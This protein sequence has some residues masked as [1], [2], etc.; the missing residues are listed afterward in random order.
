MTGDRNEFARLRELFERAV[1]MPL[2]LRR[3]FVA[4]ECDANPGLRRQLEAMLDEDAAAG[5]L[6]DRDAAALTGR[7]LTSLETR[8]C[9]PYQL[10]ALLGEGGMG[11]VYRGRR[12]DLD[13]LAA[14][15]VLRDAWVSPARRERFE[16]EQRT[17]AR[18]H[19]TG[20]AAFLDAGVTAEGTPWIAMQ[21]VEGE[22]LLDYCRS[23]SLPVNARLGLFLQVCDAVQYAHER[24]I[25]HRDLKPSNILVDAAGAPKLLDFG[26]AKRI[27][28]TQPP[29]DAT[30]TELRLM[31]PKYAAPEQVR[32]EAAGVYTDVFALGVILGELIENAPGP[33]AWDELRVIAHK[34]AHNEVAARY[35]SADALAA[36]I[37]RYLAG[38]PLQ[39]RPDTALYRL[40]KLLVRHRAAVT[41]I[42]AA[43]LLAASL[44]A[45]FTWRLKQ[46]RDEAFAAANRAQRIQAFLLNLF[47]GGDK[48]AGPAHGLTV[49]TLIDRG[50]RE[51]PAL[52]REPAVQAEVYGT[53]GRMY[54][55]LGRYDAAERLLRSAIQRHPGGAREIESRIE[56]ALLR[57]EQ[58]RF[59]EAEALARRTI[60][61][62]PAD[63][64]AQEALGRILT[65]RGRYDDAVRILEPVLA[66]REQLPE[67]DKRATAASALASAHF[68]AGR[69]DESR[70]LNERA[71]GLR[72]QVH[73]ERHPYV[74]ADRTNLGAIDVDTG[75]YAQAEPQFRRALT[76][77]ETWYGPDHPETGSALTML[78]RCLVYQ[79]RNAEAQPL[80]RRALA[81]QE[82]VLGPAHARV[83]SVINDLGNIA[84]AAARYDE[85]ELYYRRMEDIYRQTRGDAHYLVAT[86]LSNR[87]NVYL[88]KGD[89]VRA[90]ALMHD[91][92]ARYTKALSASHT[93][94]AIARIRLGRTL[95]RQKRWR[96]T[97]VESQ[98]GYDLLSAQA[99]PAV[100][101]LQGAREDLAAGYAALGQ[102]ELAA[103]YQKEWEE[104]R[105]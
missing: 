73:G 74:A 44:G 8:Q 22:Q 105:K 63:L 54:G 14:I 45:Y 6:L 96:E 49:E 104:A 86:A 4:A 26:I 25:I 48:A 50:V 3:A 90:E 1:D 87:A 65:E 5:G 42:A 69:Y 9:G 85:A 2:E 11:V 17:L 47:E 76:I 53:L 100:S 37:R 46:S 30:R 27:E 31:T 32:G 55:R 43:L 92:V 94:T 18:L 72:V 103:R 20:I 10:E 67:L 81:I 98:A 41:A 84:V 59:E 24:A 79:Q 61:L 29:A 77:V 93:S 38:E 57:S 52:D 40:R 102:A 51:A 71:L 12:P 23:R 80:L 21:L 64:E 99:Q 7:M 101:W 58:G 15:K 82:K 56:L 19:H 35:R 91:V 75:R 34:A 78:G 88:K 83:A 36:D 68:Y 39:A 60:A 62:A 95:S 70:A 13:S 97:V 28:D 66:R 16:R 89:F 33:A